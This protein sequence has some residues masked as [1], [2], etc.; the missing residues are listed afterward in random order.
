MKTYYKSRVLLSYIKT[1]LCISLKLKGENVLAIPPV[2]SVVKYYS[3]I[4]VSNFVTFHLS[5]T[6]VDSHVY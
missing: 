5:D 4:L 2:C 1:C 3:N 6:K